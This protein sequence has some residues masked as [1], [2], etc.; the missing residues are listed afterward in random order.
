MTFM[1]KAL[2]VAITIALACGP[3]AAQEA[4]GVQTRPDPAVAASSSVKGVRF[5]APGAGRVRLEVYTQAGERVFDSDFPPGGV[6][7]WDVRGLPDGA[8][9]FVLT[10]QPLQGGP[11]RTQVG[12]KVEG[13]RAAL[14]KEGGEQL[15][16][17][18]LTVTAHDGQDG[19][20]TSTTG[21]LTFRTGDVFTGQ[22]REQ[23]R[24]TADGRVGIGTADPEATL[25]VAGAIRAQGGIVFP[26]GS[27][28]TTARSMSKAAPATTNAD[29]LSASAVAGAG[30]ANRLTKW[31]DAAGTLGDS[32]ITESSGN[33]GIGTATPN[34]N[35][36]LHV[37][38]SQGTGTSLF[39]TNDNASAGAL[40]SLRAGLNPSD[41][42]VD[43]ASLN[44]LGA[45]WT[46]GAGGSFLKGKTGLLESA[47]S[48][49]GIGNINNTE[50]I[51]FYTTSQRLE[52]MRL[53]AAGNFGVGTASPAERLE[54]AGNVKVSGTGSGIVFPDGSKL[55]S[56]NGLGGGGSMT[57]TSIVAAVNDAATAG[58]INDNRITPNVAR[59]AG[60]NAWTGQ[61]TFVNGLSA[62]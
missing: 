41:Y 5:V 3:A 20:V 17:A 56:A 29:G 40:S 58:T 19:Q 24:V 14:D 13:G 32:V 53:T 4:A 55:V 9:L 12:V 51:I 8:Y 16:S 38:K 15:K 11:T 49:F 36:V 28:M 6:L 48:N 26:D 46:P 25:D 42:A 43:Y 33:V 7:D 27:V 54:V 10:A 50:P 60:Q 37:H 34:P 2:D 30:T 59:L 52:R 31:T 61:N 23:M 39:V 57:G 62:N 21:A 22:E 35:G 47:G 44:V 45:G 18:A 1:R